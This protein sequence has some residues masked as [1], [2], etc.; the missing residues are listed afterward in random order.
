[1]TITRFTVDLPDDTKQVTRTCGKCEVTHTDT[2]RGF[3]A[4]GWGLVRRRLLCPVCM[5][6]KYRGN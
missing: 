6:K 3:A 2:D 1:M 5:P 4:L